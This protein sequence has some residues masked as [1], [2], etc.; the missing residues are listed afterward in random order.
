MADTAAMSVAP[1]RLRALEQANHVR[2]ARAELKRRVKAGRLSAAEVILTCP[3]QAR[4]MSLDELLVSQRSWGRT[5]VRRL[6]R[7]LPVAENKQVGTLTERQRLAI[8]AGLNRDRVAAT[9]DSAAD[10]GG[11]VGPPRV[12]SS[13][14][15]RGSL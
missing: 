15:N 9:G 5:R 13:G 14:G 3:W 11:R 4:T 7:A 12:A 1:Q 6:L 2:L 10:P 8:A